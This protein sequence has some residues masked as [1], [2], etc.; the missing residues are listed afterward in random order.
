MSSLRQQFGIDKVHPLKVLETIDQIS[1]GLHD[2]GGNGP[3]RVSIKS[4]PTFDKDGKRTIRPETEIL[5]AL[6]RSKLIT[7]KHD[8]TRRVTDPSKKS[9][10]Y[11][12][13]VT[14]RYTFEQ[15][16]LELDQ[17]YIN[18]FTKLG[19]KLGRN[20]TVNNLIYYDIKTGDIFING[21]Y[22]TLDKQ[23]K[24]LFDQLFTASPDYA[25]RKKLTTIAR[26]YSTSPSAYILSEAFTNLRKVCH[27][28]AKVI[29]LDNSGGKLNA[30]VHPLSSQIL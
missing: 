28:N 26:K 18:I 1:A 13:Y 30:H 16:V 15:L 5:R 17:P 3:V 19:R 8:S 2:Y 25:P 14:D 6:K 20:P 29:I 9:L 7:Y 22:K 11:N 21:L 23:N 12:V 24:E 10:I 27:V 4:D